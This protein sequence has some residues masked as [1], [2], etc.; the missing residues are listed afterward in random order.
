MADTPAP[1]YGDKINTEF[2][3]ALDKQSVDELISRANRLAALIEMTKGI[4]PWSPTLTNDEK[5]WVIER[6]W[7]DNEYY[8]QHVM[9]IPRG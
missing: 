9:K 2:K 4:D 5:Q 1:E 6:C 3:K 7:L 8:L